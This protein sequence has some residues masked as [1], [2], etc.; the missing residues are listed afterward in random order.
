MIINRSGGSIV[1]IGTTIPS[2]KLEVNGAIKATEYKGLS[3]TSNFQR[4]TSSV[5]GTEGGYATTNCPLGYTLI[6]WGL[7]IDRRTQSGTSGWNNGGTLSCEQNG[8]G[9]QTGLNNY[10]GGSDQTLVVCQGLCAKD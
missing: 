6:S 7:V 8:N 5:S 10:S 9:V 1:G 3:T 4:I 2:E